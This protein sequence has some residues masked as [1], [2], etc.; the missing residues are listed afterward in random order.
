MIDAFVLARESPES[1]R[2]RLEIIG[3]DHVHVFVYMLFDDLAERHYLVVRDVNHLHVSAALTK[4]DDYLLLA[5]RMTGLVL[6]AALDSADVCLVHFHFAKEVRGPFVLHR[7]ADAVRH[8]PRRPIGADAEMLFELVRG[9][10]FLYVHDQR[11][12]HEPLFQRQVRIVE[13]GASGRGEL[14]RAFSVEALIDS[15]PLVLAGRLARDLADALRA[16]MR[17]SDTIWPAHRFEV[18]QAVIVSL[19]LLR[20]VYEVHRES[21]PF[22]RMILLHSIAR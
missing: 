1:Y 22:R 6:M 8:V 17:A 13:D 16:T 5:H 19:E 10:A 11:Q 14:L 15:R 9:H 3:E 12:G 18:L 2:I 7:L 20:Y 4:A 21:R